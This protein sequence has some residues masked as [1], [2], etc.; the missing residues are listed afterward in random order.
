MP[1]S[2]TPLATP[3]IDLPSVFDQTPLCAPSTSTLLHLSSVPSVSDSTNHPP[4][5]DVP[6][7]DTTTLFAAALRNKPVISPAFR[8]SSPG[9]HHP[10]SRPLHKHALQHQTARRS[11]TTCPSSGASNRPPLTRHSAHEFD[12]PPLFHRTHENAE[13]PH[14]TKMQMADYLR[15]FEHLFMVTP[16]RYPPFPSP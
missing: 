8:S 11:M 1:H 2:A 14:A 7:R 6:L 10:N 5:S 12:S 4:P 3:A 15:K 16:Q 9:L 13:L